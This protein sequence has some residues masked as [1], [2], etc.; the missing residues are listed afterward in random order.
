VENPRRENREIP[1]VPVKVAGRSANLSEGTAD[2]NADGKS[3]SFVVPSTQANKVATVTA[4]S[5]EGR[6][7]PK[8]SGIAVADVPDSEPDLH[9]MATKC[10]RR[11]TCFARD[12]LIQR[13]SRMR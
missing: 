4:E 6:R 9:R 13:R 10:S 8:E 5:D 3:D 1:L 11:V 12:R 2:M 7:L